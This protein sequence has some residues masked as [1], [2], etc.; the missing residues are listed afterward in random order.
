[1]EINL[2]VVWIQHGGLHTISIDGE[3]FNPTSDFAAFY[4]YISAF[5]VFQI[6][7]NSQVLIST[8]KKNQ[9]GFP[10]RGSLEVLHW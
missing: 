9:K 10:N 2:P 1:M 3:I 8:G 5:S 4:V 6:Q 7:W